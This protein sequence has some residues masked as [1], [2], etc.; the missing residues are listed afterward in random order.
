MCQ[1][2]NDASC[3]ICCKLYTIAGR[4]R[5]LKTHLLSISIEVVSKSLS[6]LLAPFDPPQNFGGLSSFR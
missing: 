6:C 5:S 4:N 2:F 1:G 3:C